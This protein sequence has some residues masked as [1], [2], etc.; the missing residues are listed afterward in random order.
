MDFIGRDALLKQ[1]EE[2]VKR[3]YIH[4][5][6]EDH[7]SEIDLWP[8]GGEPIYRDGKY[9]GMTTTTGYGYTFKK[10]VCLGFIE[11]IDSRGEKQ[12]VTHDYVTSGHFEVDIAGIRFSAK[13]NIHSPILPSKHP[14]QERDAYQATR[15]KGSDEST[16]QIV[17]TV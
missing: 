14:D 8:W 4:L 2:G 9:V 5:V 6:L 13:A 1:R 3:M 7:D 17:K 10:Q 16:V 11:N 15:G 12:T